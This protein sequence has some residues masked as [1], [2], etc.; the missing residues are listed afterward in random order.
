[1]GAGYGKW[2]IS[3]NGF[4]DGNGLEREGAVNIIFLADPDHSFDGYS[5][6][7][8]G[9]AWADLPL[10]RFT[11]IENKMAG[12]AHTTLARCYSRGLVKLMTLS[13]KVFLA[14]SLAPLFY[15]IRIRPLRRSVRLKE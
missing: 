15:R 14:A 2:R 11:T 6:A 10:V 8:S 4:P 7:G 9:H 1:M 13:S 3:W 5:L 12:N